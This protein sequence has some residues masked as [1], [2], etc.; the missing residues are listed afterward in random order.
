MIN[1]REQ[2]IIDFVTDAGECSSK[3]IFD[4][5][6]LPISYATL[7]RILSDLKSKH[8][9]VSTGLGKGT[10]YQLSPIFELIQPIDMELYYEKEVD[11]RQIKEHFNFEL[12]RETL[13]G[14]SIFTT[15]ELKK[16]ES[17]QQKYTMNIS[18]LSENEYGKELERLAIDLSWKSSQI[19]GNT[20]S[21]L[22]TEQL[23]KEKETAAGK[24]KEEAI[25]L[26][27]HKDALDFIIENKGYL[28][29]LTVSKIEEIHSMLTK[30]LGVERNLRKRRV[31]IS[32]TNYRP[33]DNEFQIL[34]ALEETCKVVN[35][36]ENV[37]EK[38]LLALVL[39]SYIQPFMDGNKRTARIVAN[40][41]LMEYGH[42]PQSFR[43]VD[44]IHYK[45]AMLLFYE[46]NNITSFKDIFIDQFQF[47]V[48][49]YF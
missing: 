22:E 27:N 36:K 41:I 6:E 47:A 1:E 2:K 48:E 34:E 5:V 16:L 44:S 42:C 15:S 25:M 46:Q 3:Q 11:E 21:L 19:E 43:T 4:A 30:E 29:Q 33:L 14:H 40:A 9:L 49:T 28:N 8:Y 17:L 37:F 38:A 10:K 7:K 12:I 23:L 26:L 24:T 35:G 32:G 45:K 20:Y 31:G 18:G 13:V 39:V